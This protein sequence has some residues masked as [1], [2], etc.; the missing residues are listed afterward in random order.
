MFDEFFDSALAER[1][2]DWRCQSDALLV[3][4]DVKPLVKLG[5]K[6]EFHRP[7]AVIVLDL[8]PEARR[9]DVYLTTYAENDD[10]IVLLHDRES[11][12]GVQSNG[13]LRLVYPWEGWREVRRAH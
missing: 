6:I 13:F 4:R 10:A 3:R 9:D 12:V 7:V 11:R 8:C 2:T 5:R 1:L